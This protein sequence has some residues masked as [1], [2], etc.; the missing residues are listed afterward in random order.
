[1]C[2]NVPVPGASVAWE[3][4]TARG[5]LQAFAAIPNDMVKFGRARVDQTCV[6]VAKTPIQGEAD[7]ETRV[8]FADHVS[9]G[10]AVNPFYHCTGSVR[11]GSKRPDL[12]IGEE[13]P[14][15]PEV[16]ATGMRSG[17]PDGPESAPN[18]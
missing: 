10:I 9:E 5:C 15:P 16:T 12:V 3:N 8:C 11:N 13:I 7:R 14:D 6:Q 1:M 4:G 2:W 17:F 18:I